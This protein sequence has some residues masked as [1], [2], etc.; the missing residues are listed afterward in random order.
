MYKKYVDSSVSQQQVDGLEELLSFIEADPYLKNI[1]YVAYML[2]TVKHE[3]AHTYHPI[4]EYGTRQYFIKRYGGQ[5]R[6]GKELGNDTPEEGYDYAG[7]GYPQTTGES[8][9]EKAERAIREQYPEV[10]EAFEARTGRKF[11]LTVGD[12]PNDKQDPQNMLDPQIAYVTM[13]YGM[14][15]G[16]FTGKKFSDYI[17]DLET[18]YLRA[19][20]IINGNDKAALIASYARDFEKVLLKS[21]V[22]LPSP[23]SSKDSRPS[24]QPGSVSGGVTGDSPASGSAPPPASADDTKEPAQGIGTTASNAADS[25]TSWLNKAAGIQE[26]VARASFLARAGRWLLTV[27]SVATA[28]FASNWEIFLIVLLLVGIAV[29]YYLFV[30]RRKSGK[31]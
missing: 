13:S 26:G 2:A 8:N 23:D 25:L 10:V 12:Q 17:N 24:D 18:N 28:F 5:T 7:K 31:T 27:G 11:D 15:T 22:S 20:R 6:K 16:M 30:V 19:R 21:K 9:Y 29:W 14:R 1:R 4:H 3:T